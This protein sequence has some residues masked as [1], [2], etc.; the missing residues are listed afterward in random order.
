MCAAIYL[1]S[2]E[3][4]AE[5]LVKLARKSNSKVVKD[6]VIFP[7]VYKGFQVRVA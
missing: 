2:K 7:E 3:G 6:Q 1:L 4:T 5:I